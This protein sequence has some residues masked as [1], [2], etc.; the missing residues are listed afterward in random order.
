M[1]NLIIITIVTLSVSYLFYIVISNKF[2]P[3]RNFIISFILGSS[4]VP[5]VILLEKG[6]LLNTTIASNH[7]L[8]TLIW[9]IIEESLKILL[10]FLFIK[11]DEERNNKFI[12]L[13]GIGVGF[14]FVESIIFSYYSGLGMFSGFLNFSLLTLILR[15]IGSLFVHTLTIATVSTGILYF[16]NK[17]KII[18]RTLFILIALAIHFFFNIFIEKNNGE[19]FLI[20]FSITWLLFLIIYILYTYLDLKKNN[21]Y[22]IK[23]FL[24][25]ISIFVGELFLFIVLMI[26][27]LVI[28]DSGLSGIKNYSERDIEQAKI[29]QQDILK[30]IDNWSLENLPEEYKEYPNDI[31]SIINKLEIINNNYSRIIFMAEEGDNL[32]GDDLAFLRSNGGEELEEVNTLIY[33]LYRKFYIDKLQT[34]IT[35]LKDEKNQG[36]L[37]LSEGKIGKNLTNEFRNY[38]NIIERLITEEEN[39]LNILKEKPNLTREE[40]DE[41]LKPIN[42]I[43]IEYKD[44]GELII[45]LSKTQS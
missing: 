32:S 30:S 34:S 11:F 15:S 3:S 41:L 39:I 40:M 36:D 14:S 19:N 7:Y 24:K 37:F 6:T 43:F 28:I 35:S 9:V 20:T 42:S 44:K 38:Q 22:K 25:Q 33:N 18:K 13:L 12:E 26:I 23:K 31:G 2:I 27:S 45:N 17:R 5:V 1:D 29:A 21:L 10:V 8:N 4:L 16:N